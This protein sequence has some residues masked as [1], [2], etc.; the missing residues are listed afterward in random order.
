[1]RGFIMFL[2]FPLLLNA[3][4][5]KSTIERAEK[6]LLEKYGKAHQER[7]KTGLK[8]VSALWQ[9]EDGSDEE[10]LQFV[11]EN[12][13]A[14]PEELS[15]IFKRFERVFESLDGHFNIMGRN[16]RWFADVDEGKMILLD[17]YL[18]AFDSSSHLTEDLFKSKIAFIILLNFKA[19]TLEELQMEGEK[20]KREE[21]ARARMA[22]RFTTRVPAEVQ[23]EIVKAFSQADNYI[24]N[25]NFY[26]G[27]ILNSQGKTL[28]PK[29][30]KLISHWG[31]R[32]EL[33]ARYLD[34][35]GLEKQQLIY[36]LMLKIINQE[37]PQEII[38]NPQFSWK[39]SDGIP[40]NSKGKE[41][42][43]RYEMFLNIFN[44]LR[45]ADPYSPQ[46]PTFIQRKFNREREI[47]EAKVKEMLENVCSSPLR[48]EVAK[49]IEKKLGRK[50][51][52]FDI[53]YNL[54]KATPKIPEKEL[55]EMVSKK[56]PDVKAFE[57][58]IPSILKKLGF[59]EDMA[60]FIGNHISVDPARGAGHAMGALLKEDKAH[61]RTRVPEQ[62]MNYKGF[63][64]A[65]HE[66]GHNVE[67]VISNSLMD[68][69]F[70]KGVPNTAFTEAFAFIFQGKDLEILGFKQ[71]DEMSQYWDVLNEFWMTYEIAGV[72][73]VDMEVWNEL[74][75]KPD[76]TK[77]ELKK[78]VI[79]KAKMIW[80]KYYAEVFGEK[81]TPILSI[82]SH[83]INS[84]LYLPDYPMGHLI[85]FQ[86]KNYLKDKI[87]GEEMLRICKI[88]SK[89]PNLWMKEAVGEELSEKPL[90]EQTEI[91]LQKLKK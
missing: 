86:I 34:K 6:L 18:S 53:W 78:V 17:E 46:Y 69:H 71:E 74:Y 31:L 84:A 19:P 41:P 75:K 64:I 4:V 57:K 1:M 30:L 48:F 62:G 42:D 23:Q 72:S 61:L 83:M 3:Q 10:F 35:D 88:G 8:Q 77:E 28:F 33:K 76:M 43:T 70:L 87:L 21:W 82:Y 47:P 58:E 51:R 7:I 50:L 44:A 26:L 37:I 2:I 25:Y 67:Q 11:E 32:D 20:L 63:N 22:M 9:K 38:N 79:E 52:P 15:L 66:L 90:L 14:S 45:K 36:E 55:D 27:N 85:A 54:L 12:F 39:I 65:M 60:E 13:A 40:K 89:I 68:Y 91:A 49:I 56:F 24:S 73:L 29:D 81:D 59:K 16:L 80:N 5:Q